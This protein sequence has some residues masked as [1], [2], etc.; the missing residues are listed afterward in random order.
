MT[1]GNF[2]MK[3]IVY[4][5]YDWDD[6]AMF[7]P[8]RIVLFAKDKNSGLKEIEVSTE[9]F[10]HTRSK[11]G[12]ESCKVFITQDNGV[13]V[14][15]LNSPSLVAVDLL[16]YE[17]NNDDATGSFKQF[18]DCANDYFM[19]DLKTALKNKTFGPSFKDLQEH[20]QTQEL[21]NNVRIITARGH[22]PT[23]LHKG[24]VYLKTV[25]LIKCVPPVENM[26][27]CSFKGLN[28]KMVASAQNPS[29][30]KKNI[31]MSI[32]DQ[33]HTKALND[34]NFHTFG[35]SDDDK[36]TMTLV[37]QA[38]QA[39]LKVGRWSNFEINLYFTGNK[40]KERQVLLSL[41][42]EVA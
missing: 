28:S 16:N 14:G 22:N 15:S 24:L 30:A 37:E 18:R 20:C 8:T 13:A 17:V 19:R 40:K 41:V 2:N 38:L 11:V 4:A 32:L 21:A 25:G 3:K 5:N 36:K 10:A 1:K 34:N 31:L 9:T 42:P 23:T 12:I 7:M 26:F 6:N 29:E 39:E 35:F 27:P 33:I